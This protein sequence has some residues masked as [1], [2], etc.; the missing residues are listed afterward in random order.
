M[1]FDRLKL[2]KFKLVPMMKQKG[3]WLWAAKYGGVFAVF[4]VFFVP[5]QTRLSAYATKAFSLKSEI[6]SIKKIGTE[7]LSKAEMDGLRAR[8]EQFESKLSDPSRS[9]ELLDG[10]SEEAQ[11]NHFQVIQIYSDNPVP[12]KDGLSLLPVSFRIET[13]VKSLASFLKSLEESLKGA[14][15]LESLHLQKTPAQTETLQCDITLSFILK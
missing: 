3:L 5:I 8:I 11:K 2:L 14:F 6:S 13:D 1:I 9:P 4:L 10:I 15:V 12:L 7:L